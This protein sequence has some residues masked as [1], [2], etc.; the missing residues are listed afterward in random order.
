MS[1]LGNFGTLAGTNGVTGYNYSTGGI[2]GGVDRQI[3]PG[4]TMGLLLGYDQST[5]SDSTGSAVTMTGGQA[6]LYGGMKM[7]EWNLGAVLTGALNSYSTEPLVP[8][9]DGHRHGAG[10]AMER[11]AVSWL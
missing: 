8:G 11:P 7:D 1:G 9:P 3:A 2:V 6:G 4:Q 5:M 10:H